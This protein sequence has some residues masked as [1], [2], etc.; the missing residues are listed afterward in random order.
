VRRWVETPTFVRGIPVSVDASIGIAI[1][2][3]DGND[4][5]QLVRRADVAMY[6][7]KQGRSGVLRYEQGLDVQDAGKLVLMT[8]LRAAVEREE[9]EVHY[10]PV[11]STVGATLR[12]VEALVRWRHPTRGLMPPSTFLPLAEHTRLVVAL[13]AF[14]LREAVRQCAIWQRHGSDVGLAVNMTVLDLLEPDLVHRVEQTLAANILPPSSLTIEITE[15]ALV[16]EPARVRRALEGLRALGVRIAIDDFGT[17]YSSLSYLRQLP[18]DVLKIDRSFV[19]DLDASDASVAIVAAAVELAHR[20]GLVVVA[21]GVEDDSQY[22]CLELLGCDLIQG[23]LI[24]PPVTA[25]ALSVR[26]E[27]ASRSADDD[28]AAA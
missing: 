24:S 20:L 23:Y 21:E 12:S 2:P 10:Q 5:A 19:A 9:L 27:E 7:A 18:I 3:D 26:M 28:L 4:V 13:N 1:A 14:V 16:Q 17:G 25:S 11:V 8:E 22:D 6:A 15:N